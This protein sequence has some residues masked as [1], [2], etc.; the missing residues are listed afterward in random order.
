VKPV[1]VS[2]AEHA[3]AK[4]NLALHV[5]GR[6]ADGYHLIESLSVFTG[7][8]D[9]I[10]AAPA[11]RD[12]F[13]VTGPFAAQV[14]L[15]EDNLVIRARDA[16]RALFGENADQPVA[17]SLEKNMPVASGIG[18][19]SSDAAAALRALARPWGMRRK[20]DALNRVALFL[21]ADV[22]MCL[23]RRPL[24][25]RGIGERIEEI[26]A[27]PA[28][29]L[30]L[31]NP[32]VAVP[33]PKVFAALKERNNPPLPPLPAAM[34]SAALLDWLGSTRNDLAAPAL[35]LAPEIATA[36]SALADQGAQFARMSGSGA[37][38]FGIYDDAQSAARAATAI[39]SN[40]PD[41]F[42]TATETTG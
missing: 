1:V 33:T 25:A 10:V 30:V 27:F 9:W 39:A 38:C 31:V 17:I 20:D 35:S 29:S 36:L 3:P 5:T 19:G 42:V 7:F 11:E 15:D 34:T 8:G 4:I 16:L 6:R 28:L 26:E 18:G 22:P 12:E 37:T 41:W 14:P 32:G 21:G 40:H 13:T 2:L 24:I 23:A